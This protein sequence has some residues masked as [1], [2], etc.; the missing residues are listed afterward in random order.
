[1]GK[2]VEDYTTKVNSNDMSKIVSKMDLLQT[3]F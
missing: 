2:F 1:M 3:T